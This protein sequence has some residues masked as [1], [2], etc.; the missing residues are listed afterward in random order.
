MASFQSEQ[1]DVTI[2]DKGNLSVKFV[3]YGIPKFVSYQMT[4]EVDVTFL[5]SAKSIN[6]NLN[7]S[8]QMTS[9][10]KHI[11]HGQLS[12]KLKSA[13]LGVSSTLSLVKYKNLVVKDLTN[14]I[15]L[16]VG[17]V[18][19]SF[20]GPP[21]AAPKVESYAANIGVTSAAVKVAPLTPTVD[22]ASS[23]VVEDDVL[24]IE[25]PESAR[26]KQVVLKMI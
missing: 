13:K 14:K 1:T 18:E 15:E 10:T 5:G 12:S 17:S 21:P 20:N 2:D 3:E 24:T 6:F 16:K 26:I 9:S 19:K 8:R 4:G 7:S 25:I 23:A 22:I 11:V